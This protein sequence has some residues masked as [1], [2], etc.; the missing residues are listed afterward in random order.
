V[1]LNGEGIVGGVEEEVNE[2]LCEGLCMSS[3]MLK[4]FWKIFFREKIGAECIAT[5]QKLSARF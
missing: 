5:L 3:E 2:I 4:T 1:L